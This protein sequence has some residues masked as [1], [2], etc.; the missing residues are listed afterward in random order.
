[1]GTIAGT[2]AGQAQSLDGLYT[3]LQG[4]ASFHNDSNNEGILLDIEA[5]SKAGYAV[6]G[7]VGNKFENGLRFDFGIHYRS[8]E[9]DNLEITADRGYFAPVFPAGTL[10]G[11]DTDA[12][13]VDLDGKVT[14]LT[15]MGNAYYDID[16]GSAF[17]PFFGGGVGLARLRQD[18]SF[19]A[20]GIEIDVVDDSDSVLAYQGS[21]GVAV[22]VTESIGLSLSYQYLG[23]AESELVDGA[24]DP[25]DSE[26]SSHNV[27][28]G[29]RFT[30]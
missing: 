20:L 13:G 28:F 10:T 19:T 26:Y 25:F 14:A 1:M 15:F 30:N 11:V 29:I 7:T 17:T 8:N 9:L 21:A 3:E 6:G 4:G 18:A 27:M 5:Q 24:G 12:L 16:T 22:D 23:T 2:A